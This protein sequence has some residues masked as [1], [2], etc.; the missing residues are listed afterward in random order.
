MQRRNFL[1]AD[2]K[3]CSGCGEVKP[4]S[5]FYSRGRKIQSKCKLCVT[6]RQRARR[7]AG[8]TQALERARYHGNPRVRAL[9]AANTARWKARNPDKLRAENAVATA[10]RRGDLV[11]QPCEVCGEKAQAHHED[12]AR[13]LDVR[14]LCPLHHARQHAAEGRLRTR[15]A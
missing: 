15:L 8:L 6:R 2:K 9:V 7:D 14:W 10:I 11:R 12:Y 3:G 1:A 4:R 5:D 13:P